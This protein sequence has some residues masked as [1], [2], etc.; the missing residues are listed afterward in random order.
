MSAW[1]HSDFECSVSRVWEQGDKARQLP[2]LWGHVHLG[3]KL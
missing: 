1:Q 2:G 3:P